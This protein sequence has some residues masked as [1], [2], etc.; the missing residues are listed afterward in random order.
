MNLPEYY[1]KTLFRR[2]L[3]H[4]L[5]MGVAA[6]IGAVAIMIVDREDPVSVLWGKV[7]PPVV[8]PGQVVTFHYGSIKHDEYGGNITR[9]IVDGRGL[10]FHLTDTG[11]SGDKLERY[12]EGEVVKEFPVPCGISV[13]GATYH[14]EA[15]LYKKW[16]L[17]QYMWP[18]KRHINYPFTVIQSPH[19]TACGFTGDLGGGGQGLQ[20]VQGEPGKTGPAGGAQGIQGIQGAP[21]AEAARPRIIHKVWIEPTT[22]VPGQKFAVHID[23]TMNQLCPG[24]THWSI[25]RASDGVEVLNI[26]QPTVPTKLGVNNLANTRT[27]PATVLPGEYY[28]IASVHEFCGP[29]RTTFIATTEHVPF[30][31]K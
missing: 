30:T 12:K 29:D 14:S 5:P 1:R 24:E 7:I 15:S 17:V 16:N 11:V 28:Y 2:I 8:T 19:N 26:T 4:I 9:W 21:G 10:V 31:V 13:G 23:V 20:G 25:I 22:M 6:V 18:I 3:C 27:L